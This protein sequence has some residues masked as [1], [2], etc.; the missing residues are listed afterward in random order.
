M[1][2]EEFTYR[3]LR[4]RRAHQRRRED[5]LRLATTFVYLIAAV[6]LIVALVKL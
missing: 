3:G 5:A 4:R 1:T 2:P 6:A